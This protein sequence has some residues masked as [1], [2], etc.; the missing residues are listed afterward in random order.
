M[1]KHVALSVT[2]SEEI[3]NFY[4]EVL[5]F[6]MKH[7]FTLN[8]Y[9]SQKIFNVNTLTDVYVLRRQDLEFEIFISLK[10][11]KRVFSHIC[12]SYQNPEIVYENALKSGYKTITKDGANH[13]TWFIWDKSGNMFEIKEI[14][15]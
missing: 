9:L 7:K 1:L 5:I 11:E 8:S 4:E 2:D 13:C 10:K 14:Q 6:R 15:D 3:E 12:L